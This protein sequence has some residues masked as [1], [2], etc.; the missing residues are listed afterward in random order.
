METKEFARKTF[1]VQAV[2]VTLENYREVAEWCKG[3][4]VFESTKMLGTTTKLPVIK[5]KGQGDNRGKEFKATLGCYVVE[6]KG[7]FRSYR[8]PQFWSSF[9]ELSRDGI[10][11]ANEVEEY[12][13]NS[14][15]TTPEHDEAASEQALETQQA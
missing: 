2:E 15:V 13:P 6:L 5:I 11:I 1:T 4:V 10:S 3:E 9:E 7:S 12:D 14:T 8:P